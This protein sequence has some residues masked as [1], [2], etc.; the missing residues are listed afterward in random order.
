MSQEGERRG[1]ELREMRHEQCV[2]QQEERE[3]E[4]AERRPPRQSIRNCRNS[5]ISTT[6][7]RV[8]TKRV[9]PG[10]RKKVVPPCQK[11]RGAMPKWVECY[12]TPGGDGDARGELGEQGFVKK[13]APVPEISAKL[14]RTPL[15]TEKT[16]ISTTV[17]RVGTKRVSPESERLDAKMSEIHEPD[18]ATLSKY[19]NSN[20]FGT[21]KARA[22]S[23]ISSG[24]KR[25]RRWEDGIALMGNRWV[26]FY[27][28]S[29]GDS[30]VWGEL[31]GHGNRENSAPNPEIF[32]ISSYSA[33]LQRMGDIYRCAGPVMTKGIPFESYRRVGL[34]SQ[35][36]RGTDKRSSRYRVGEVGMTKARGWLIL[37]GELG[38]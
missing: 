21:T 1:E 22:T 4:A 37:V 14:S 23:C 34:E 31:G 27:E 29:G 5:H 3:E 25:G 36:A 11:A 8:G 16:H 2:G 20:K 33:F 38:E 19:K 35:F 7:E 28:T 18:L 32:H 10:S 30:D 6:V 15:Y 9:S 17:E 13:G 12:E 24:P 26:E